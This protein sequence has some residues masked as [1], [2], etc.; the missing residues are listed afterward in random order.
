ML[1]D[2]VWLAP[3]A[4]LSPPLLLTPSLL[5]PYTLLTPCFLLT[6][7]SPLPQ[8]DARRNKVK[9]ARKRREDR[10]AAKKADMLAVSFFKL[11]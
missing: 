11:E 9:E 3:P 6:P 10:Q 4:A 8:A 1:A 7:Y 2:Q 5:S